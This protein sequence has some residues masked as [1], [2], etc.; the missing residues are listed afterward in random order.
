MPEQS[1]YSQVGATGSGN[2]E[3]STPNASTDA[4]AQAVQPPEQ[5]TDE[6]ITASKLNQILSDWDR[7]VQSRQDKMASSLDKRVAKAQQEA[8]AAIELLKNSGGNLTPEQEA[9]IKQSAINRAIAS[10][11]PASDSQPELVQR[12]APDPISAY[13]NQTLEE[14]MTEAKVYISPAE[15]KVLIPN[16][17]QMKPHDVINAFKTIIDDRAATTKPGPSSR[18]PFT[19]GANIPGNEALKAQYDQ[20]LKALPRTGNRGE[21]IARLKARYQQKG[22]DIT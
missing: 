22:L 19:Q 7:K 20:E 11:E 1:Y 14:M 2:P 21:L 9:T 8:Q 4:A 15:A 5:T 10:A 13:V 12:Q 17:N 18:L 6:V 3:A 16:I